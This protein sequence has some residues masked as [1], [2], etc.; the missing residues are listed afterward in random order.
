MKF[1]FAD[2]I[3]QIDPGFNFER[4]E[5]SPERRVQ[6]DDVY[7][8]EYFDTPPYDGMLVSRAI[9][10]DRSSKGK[11]STPQSMRFK[12]EGARSFLRYNPSSGR[13]HPRYHHGKQRHV[14][15]LGRE[16]SSLVEAYLR[17]RRSPALG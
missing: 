15:E 14:S 12:R 7:P 11:Y 3:D 16:G 1:I 4:D 17:G 2:S 8:H 13:A 9:I 10:G 6:R 5:F